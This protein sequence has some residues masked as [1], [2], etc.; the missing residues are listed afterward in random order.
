MESTGLGGNRLQPMAKVILWNEASL[1]MVSGVTPAFLGG[2]GEGGLT[3]ALG[4]EEMVH[5]VT[6]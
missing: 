6:E 1:E 2:S 3:G 4:L 5:Y